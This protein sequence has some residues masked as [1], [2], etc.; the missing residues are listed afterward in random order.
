LIAVHGVLSQKQA[1]E[2][3][4]L[5]KQQ[6]SHYVLTG[7]TARRLHTTSPTRVVYIHQAGGNQRAALKDAATAPGA[8]FDSVRAALGDKPA[9]TPA[10]QA[11]EAARAEATSE[12]ESVPE[13]VS[14][15]A[16]KLTNALL[17]LAQG[18]DTAADLAESSGV[19]IMRALVTAVD[20]YV[21]RTNLPLSKAQRKLHVVVPDDEMVTA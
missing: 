14:K 2:R 10:R 21:R 13:N 15:Q 7:Q 5:T 18:G 20:A 11:R 16:V 1:S 19:D 8:T 12:S 6:V 3:Y 4:G 17:V 9:D